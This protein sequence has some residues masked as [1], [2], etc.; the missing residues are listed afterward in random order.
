MRSAMV[1][2][3]L[4]CTSGLSLPVFAQKLEVPRRHLRAPGPPLPAEEAVRKMTVPEGFTVELVAAEPDIVNPVAMFIDERGRFWIAESVEYPR[5]SPGVGRDR[6]KVLEDTDGDG[7]VDRTTLFAEG[8][9]IPSGIAVGYG[10]VWVSNPPDLLYLQ[11]TDGDLRADRSTVVLTG[12][13]RTDTH[14]MPNSLTWGPDGWLYGLNGIFNQCRVNYPKDHPRYRKDRPDWSFNA[15]VF[16]VHPRTH[17]FEIFCEGTSNPW[18]IAINDA[19]DMFLSACV[20]DHLWHVAESGYYIRQRGPYRQHS[21]PLESIVKHKHVQAAYCG[22]VWFDSPA[23]PPEYRNTLYMG[24]VHSGSLNAD[25]VR[26]RGGT[27]FGEPHPGFTPQAGT[28]NKDEQQSI[29]KTGDPAAPRLADLLTANDPWFVPVAQKIGP[30]GCIYILDWY[31]QYHCYQ[32]A[33]AD[34][35]GIERAKGR[36]YRLRYQQTPYAHGLDLASR[37]DAELI[38]LLGDPNVFFRETAQRLLSERGNP[39]TAKQL[40]QILQREESKVFQRHALWARAGFPDHDQSWLAPLL[41]SADPFQRNWGVRLAASRGPQGEAILAAHNYCLNRDDLQDWEL[42]AIAVALG[43]A[44]RASRQLEQMFNLV[45]RAPDDQYLQQM[46]WENCHREIAAQPEKFA[47]I[48]DRLDTATPAQQAAVAPFLP[49]IIRLLAETQSVPGELLGQI[50]G[51]AIAPKRAGLSC[52]FPENIRLQCLQELL[53]CVR[54][55]V[56]SGPRFESAREQLAPVLLSAEEEQNEAEQFQFLMTLLTAYWNDD[57]ARAALLTAFQSSQFSE[58][59][60]IEILKTLLALNDP[61]AI[62]SAERV[63]QQLQEQGKFRFALLSTLAQSPQPRIG[64]IILDHLAQL[65]S[66]ELP[67][68]VEI[69]TQRPEW[70]TALLRKIAD[71]QVEKSLLNM[72]QLQRLARLPNPEL[73]EQLKKVYGTVQFQTT[74]ERRAILTNR[75]DHVRSHRGDP[76]RGSEVFKRVCAQCHKIYGEGND[77]GPDLTSNGRSNWEQLFTNVM[78]PSAVIGQAYQARLLVTTDGRVLTGLPIEETSERVLLKIQGGKT[79]SVPRAEIEEYRVSDR[80]L[81]PDQLEQ[82]MTMQ[83]F[84]DLFAFLSLDLPPSHP[85]AKFIPGSP[86]FDNP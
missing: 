40:E 65:D 76:Q 39:E 80:S 12:F 77:V 2:I 64:N 30:D 26:R 46:V 52:S 49:R 6:I 29:A 45:A 63:L 10:G 24:N 9:N 57:T 61:Q 59:Q 31:D 75:R 66:S 69:L 58:D 14:E 74:R 73:Q 20:I 35:E 82:T 22:I 23:Y 44:Q 32:D 50:S 4:L 34:P 18:G 7:K 48:M 72:N 67:M 70:A 33:Q 19:G 84:T 43:K 62:S 79:E 85:D 47:A 5:L 71:G 17:A 38:N 55:K 53:E 13:G 41:S 42:P 28:W 60:R 3:S 54:G 1:W 21:W 81:M 56:L 8:L 11:D 86:R 25:V 68:A 15:A 83:E 27:Y 51:Q 37:S 36:L 78:E 16:R